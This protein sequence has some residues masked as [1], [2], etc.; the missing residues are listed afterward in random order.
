[1]HQLFSSAMSDS[2]VG[3]IVSIVSTVTPKMDEQYVE[4]SNI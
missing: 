1:M 2:L 3:S 4:D